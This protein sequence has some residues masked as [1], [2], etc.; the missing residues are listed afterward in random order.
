MIFPCRGLYAITPDGLPAEILLPQVEAAL[1][2]GVAVVQ[3]RE[4]NEQLRH[5]TAQSLKSLCDQYN[6]PLLINDD[7]KLAAL[8]G[9]DGVHLGRHDQSISMARSYLGE[10]AI[11]GI[12]CYNDVEQARFAEQ[13]GASYVAFGRFFPSG[14][15]PLASPAELK[16]LTQAKQ[17]I[18]LPIVA[19]GGILPNNGQQ[20]LLA[21]ADLLAVVGGI[22]D[23]E[24]LQSALDFRALFN[25]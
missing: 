10:H 8:I 9:A 7:Y 17:Q 16:T 23:S 12:S 25:M 2:G 11:I 22:F 14:T 21:G 5:A 20:L 1:Q 24:P 3:Y 13:Q 4:K 19:I 15:K 18:N 6:I